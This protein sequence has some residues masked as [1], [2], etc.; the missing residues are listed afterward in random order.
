MIKILEVSQPIQYNN[1]LKNLKKF[2]KNNFISAGT[3]SRHNPEEFQKRQRQ[4]FGTP[5]EMEENDA[6][7]RP[8][9][10]N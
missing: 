5:E 6:M 1:P 9:I 8:E 2:A 7:E 10:F 3:L 4:Y